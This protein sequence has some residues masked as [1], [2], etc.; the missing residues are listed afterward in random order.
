MEI[1]SKKPKSEKTSI[2]ESVNKK[3]GSSV[4]IL[5]PS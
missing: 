3:K 1:A 5:S 2:N 4:R